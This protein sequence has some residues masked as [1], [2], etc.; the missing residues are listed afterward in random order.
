MTNSLINE[1]ICAR[2]TDTNFAAWMYQPKLYLNVLYVEPG[3]I[4]LPFM[5][6]GMTELF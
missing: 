3:N 2:C 5:P 6:M 4:K 1:E